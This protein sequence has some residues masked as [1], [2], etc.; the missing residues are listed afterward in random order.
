MALCLY[1][2]PSRNLSQFIVRG[3]CSGTPKLSI[4]PYIDRIIT[5]YPG[6]LMSH[7]RSLR[8]LH[9]SLPNG[10]PTWVSSATIVGGD[11]VPEDLSLPGPP[12]CLSKRDVLD[13]TERLDW[14]VERERRFRRYLCKTPTYQNAKGLRQDLL[15]GGY[16][17]SVL[18]TASVRC[19]QS[20]DVDAQRSRSRG[21]EGEYPIQL[22]LEFDLC[23]HDRLSRVKAEPW[24]RDAKDGRRIY[25]PSL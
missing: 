9:I 3:L 8:C 24:F 22:S 15:L 25:S 12:I 16:R 20:D 21:T 7:C 23:N 19:V 18:V 10:M 14:P 13:M 11:I 17:G 1:A 5:R 6:Y 4:E 2:R